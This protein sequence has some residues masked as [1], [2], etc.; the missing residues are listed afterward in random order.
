MDQGCSWISRCDLSSFV[1][2]WSR[3]GKD[4]ARAVARELRVGR[5]DVQLG[6]AGGQGLVDYS[7]GGSAR[8]SNGVS[9][10]RRGGH[11]VRAV[12]RTLGEGDGEDE[13][14]EYKDVWH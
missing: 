3:R 1:G 11:V 9:R 5:L 6:A 10:T 8:I 13:R 2:I 7:I 14:S 4:G 12:L